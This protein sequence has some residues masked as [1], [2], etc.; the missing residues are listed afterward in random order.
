MISH[1]GT[2]ARREERCFRDAVLLLYYFVSSCLRVRILSAAS[3]RLCVRCFVLCFLALSQVG[4]AADEMLV[5]P[6]STFTVIQHYEG[7]Y[8]SS[9]HFTKGKHQ[10]ITFGDSYPW[11]A[12]FYIAPNEEWI[13]Q[14]QKTGSGDNTAFLY[15]LESNHRLW[16]M[17]ESLYDLAFAFLQRVPGMSDASLYHTGVKFD[18]WD[19]KAGLLRFTFDG[20]KNGGG[21][22]T[23]KLAYRLKDHIITEP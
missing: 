23:R 5:S 22:I 19:L 3:S 7:N 16:R 15:R 1:E 12:L 4:Q 13:L 9:L 20:T 17:E 8:T 10:D 2:K 18:S 11:P 21:S 14:I 6:R